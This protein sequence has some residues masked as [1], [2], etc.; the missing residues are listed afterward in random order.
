MQPLL[1]CKS[2]KY[3]ISLV[4]VCSLRSPQCNAHVL[5]Y[6]LWPVELSNN[7][8]DYLINGTAMHMHYIVICG[9]SNSTIVFQT[10]S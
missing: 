1:Q 8:P 10:I 6:N 2:N 4:S 9:L 7:F 5:Y 3:Y